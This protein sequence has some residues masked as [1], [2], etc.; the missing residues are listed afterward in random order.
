MYDHV[1]GSV[2]HQHMKDVYYELN[3]PTHNITTQYK[4]KFASNEKFF[5]LLNG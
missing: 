3:H 2:I 4:V 5:M 1:L